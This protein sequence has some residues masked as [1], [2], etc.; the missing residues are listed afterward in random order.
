MQGLNQLIQAMSHFSKRIITEKVSGI[1]Y[2]EFVPVNQEGGKGLLNVV[3]YSEESSAD[4]D[5]GLIIDNTTSS[6][7]ADITFSL[8]QSP[9]VAWTNTITYTDRE[10]EILERNAGI[11]VAIRKMD[12]L[13]RIANQILQNTAFHGHKKG[14]LTGL[15]NNPEVALST[16]TITG[17]WS[18][19]TGQELFNLVY[20]MFLKVFEQTD[21]IA[22]PDTIA[23][24]SREHAILAGAE[25][26][27]TGGDSTVLESLLKAMQGAAGKPIDIKPMPGKSGLGIGKNGTNRIIA[28]TNDEDHIEMNV[29]VS[30]ETLKIVQKSSTQVE[31]GMRMDF[32]GVTFFEPKSAIY[33]DYKIK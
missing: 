4:L 31:T 3:H 23:I 26:K 30:P 17:D 1:V 27:E 28:Y 18:T 24:P 13:N 32:G 10:L 19:K 22:V 14:R 2:P 15:L 5:G 12:A 6:E 21:F 25:R 16:Q 20:G 33:I 8:G 11:N 7:Q 29:P 9:I